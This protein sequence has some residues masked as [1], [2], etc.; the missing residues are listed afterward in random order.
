M[1]QTLLKLRH[2]HSRKTQSHTLQN[3]L[4]HEQTCHNHATLTR[5]TMHTHTPAPAHTYTHTH[6]QC[7]CGTS[8]FG[9]LSLNLFTSDRI[10][11]CP[12]LHLYCTHI[13]HAH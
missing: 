3:S 12:T 6:T 10:T 7:M 11:C 13:Q 1:S 4:Q 2:L 5:W 8:T 9:F